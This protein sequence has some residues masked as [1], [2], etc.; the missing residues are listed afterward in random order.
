MKKK[1][2][3][4]SRIHSTFGRQAVCAKQGQYDEYCTTEALTDEEVCQTLTSVVDTLTTQWS[5]YWS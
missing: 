4:R 5:R 2:I 1:R 3:D